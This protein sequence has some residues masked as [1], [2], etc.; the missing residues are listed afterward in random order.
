MAGN[1]GL[2]FRMRVHRY[3]DPVPTDG[4]PF[5]HAVC[6]F[7]NTVIRSNTNSRFTIN[8]C[9]Y[10]DRYQGL[11]DLRRRLKSSVRIAGGGKVSVNGEEQQCTC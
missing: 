11:S 3:F 4:V 7:D 5:E 9:P 1:V 2:E 8:F 10:R 6:H